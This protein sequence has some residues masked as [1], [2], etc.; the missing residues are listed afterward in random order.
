MFAAWIEP[1]LKDGN[2]RVRSQEAQ[3][4]REW[5]EAVEGS[6]FKLR[7]LSRRCRT[8]RSS[9]SRNRCGSSEGAEQIGDLERSIAAKLEVA[10]SQQELDHSAW[11]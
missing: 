1:A 3:D 8:R 6:G 7:G 9:G 5:L 10:G 2:L 11:N 4:H